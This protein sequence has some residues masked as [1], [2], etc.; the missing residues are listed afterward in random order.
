MSTHS[1]IPTFF[2]IAFSLFLLTSCG[3]GND[4]QASPAVNSTPVTPVAEKI[5]VVGAGLA[6]LTAA[7]DMKVA[8]DVLNYAN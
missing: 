8:I 6:G 5:I 2:I 7:R 3:G 4:Q 1:K